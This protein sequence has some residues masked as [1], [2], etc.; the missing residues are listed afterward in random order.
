MSFSKMLHCVLYYL[1]ALLNSPW[2]LTMMRC[3]N[4]P[5]WA[6]MSKRRQPGS[7]GYWGQPSLSLQG[8]A[9]W[10]MG[11]TTPSFLLSTCS[12]PWSTPPTHNFTWESTVV[13]LKTYRNETKCD[14]FSMLV[15]PHI[16][17]AFFSLFQARGHVG[18]PTQFK[19]FCISGKKFCWDRAG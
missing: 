13:T 16:C 18:Q 10:C 14:C 4:G 17:E 5:L 15:S 12:L 6:L 2:L 7:P 8:S 11:W 9:G 3:G 1:L 19:E